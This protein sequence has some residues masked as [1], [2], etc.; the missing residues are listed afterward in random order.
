MKY[1]FLLLMVMFGAG[2]SWG[3]E[4]RCPY[5][6]G[7]QCFRIVN[8]TI[9]GEI[10]RTSPSGCRV[11]VRDF[12]DADERAYQFLDVTI[13]SATR[14]IKDRR[15]AQLSDIHVGDDVTIRYRRCLSGE[16][17]AEVIRVD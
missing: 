13:T 12:Q 1:L 5:P 16:Y 11:Q 7:A 9:S 17:L 4:A 15:A 3:Q 6:P 10:E 2:V 14:I 8:A